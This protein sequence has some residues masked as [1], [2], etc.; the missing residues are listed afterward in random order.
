MKLEGGNPSGSFKDRGLAMGLGLAWACGAQQVC[1]PTQGNA[2]VAAVA[3]GSGVHDGERLLEFDPLA[4]LDSIAEL[5]AW[6][7]RRVHD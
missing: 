2:G 3:V 4:L 6:L 7:S 5:P 1:L